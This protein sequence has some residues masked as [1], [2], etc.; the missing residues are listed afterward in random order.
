[1]KSCEKSYN[2]Y[3][4]SHSCEVYIAG[5]INQDFFRY[6]TDKITLDYLDM[7]LN[8]RYMLMITKATQITDHS[9]TLIDHIYANTPQKIMFNLRCLPRGYF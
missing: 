9:A 8:L 4:D 5:D 1:M 3:L 7:P 6:S 2:I